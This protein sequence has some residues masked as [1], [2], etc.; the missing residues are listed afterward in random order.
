L[1]ARCSGGFGFLL[2]YAGGGRVAR[3]IVLESLTIN[4]VA[5]ARKYSLVSGFAY[6]FS[7]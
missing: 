6:L 7:L 4:L 3:G 2:A 5:V 1:A